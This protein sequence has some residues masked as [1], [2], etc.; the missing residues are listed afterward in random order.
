MDAGN[1]LNLTTHTH[2]HHFHP[3][4]G[5]NLTT[6]SNNH[7]HDGRPTIFAIFCNGKARMF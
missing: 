1:Q 4:K 3:A 2:Y 5:G 6:I 7:P